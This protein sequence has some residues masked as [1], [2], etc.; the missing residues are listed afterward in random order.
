MLHAPDLY[1]EKLVVGP[2]SKHAVNLD[3]PVAQNLRAIARCLEREVTDLV[4]IVLDRPRHETLIAEIRAT[5]ARIR[6]ISDGQARTSRPC[7]IPR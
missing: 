1:M 4:V 5:G 2:T 7:T 3:A 6:L